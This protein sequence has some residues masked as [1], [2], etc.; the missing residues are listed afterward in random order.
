MEKI[1][2]HFAQIG[3]IFIRRAET[4]VNPYA[5]LSSKTMARENTQ[6]NQRRID[7][8]FGQPGIEAQAEL[9]A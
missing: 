7:V 6:L 4:L 3:K 5:H 9:T 1:Q 8:N 2:K